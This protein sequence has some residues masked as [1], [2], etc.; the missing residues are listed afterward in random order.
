MPYFCFLR[1]YI[2]VIYLRFAFYAQPT[3]NQEGS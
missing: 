2:Y 3:M 1:I